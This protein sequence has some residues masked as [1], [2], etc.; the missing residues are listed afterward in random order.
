MPGK[1][2]RLHPGIARPSP[3]ALR[4]RAEVRLVVKVP[5]AKFSEAILTNSPPR[6]FGVDA[7]I[8]MF[9]VT[10][11]EY[12]PVTGSLVPSEFLK[13]SAE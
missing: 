3:P 2:D 5:S 4:P 1:I 8:K 7:Y 10:Q 11:N 6:I 9:S 13:E 12:V